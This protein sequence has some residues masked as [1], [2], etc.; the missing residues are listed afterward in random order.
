MRKDSELGGALAGD[1]TSSRPQAGTITLV[2]GP[3][4]PAADYDVALLDLDGV[5]Y[6]G[7]GA[8]PGAIDAL[9]QARAGGM[10]LA[11]VTN[12]ASRSPSAVAAQLTGLGIPAGAAD[13][14]TSAQ[15]AASLIASR[16]P[17]GSRVLVAGAIGLRLAL[18]A[19]GLIPV[20]VAADKPAAV[21]QGY[22][23][24]MSY[25]LLAEAALAVRDGALFVAANADATLPTPRGLQP[26]NGAVLQVII[27]STGRQPLVA[28]K[29]EPPLHRE[30]V[31]RTGAKRPL[32]VGDRLDT[33][34][35]GATR[36]GADS[37][38]VLTGVSTPR[39]LVL[40]P[41]SQRPAYVAADLGG[42]LE[43]QPVVNGLDLAGASAVRCGG[44]TAAR[45][46]VGEPLGLY[47]DGLPIDA[48]R[49]LCALSWSGDAMTPEMADRALGA[50]SNRLGVRSARI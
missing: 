31:A 1:S 4:A 38:L 6:T 49:A 33:D 10:R 14:V 18:R 40:A 36:G 23:P 11:F 50:I 12:N 41:P 28:G 20:S 13:V 26:G 16:V 34:I 45:G 29:P 37:M 25:G 46:S 15:A 47:G 22:A 7:S 39:E 5:V 24:D 17:A 9:A 35:E 2:P 21:V 32:V 42:L 8:V 48:L 3:R 44:W 27:H 43:A 30:A 19:R